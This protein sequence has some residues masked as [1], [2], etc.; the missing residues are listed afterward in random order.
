MEEF[1]ESAQCS[2]SF[3]LVKSVLGQRRTDVKIPP[4]KGL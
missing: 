3:V 4:K 1:S 2:L